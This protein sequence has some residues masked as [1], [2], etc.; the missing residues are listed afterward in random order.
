MCYESDGL[1]HVESMDESPL[2]SPTLEKPKIL[3]WQWGSN[4]S[5]FASEG[6]DVTLYQALV[7]FLVQS[8]TY[9]YIYIYVYTYVY[10]YICEQIGTHI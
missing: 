8:L 7:V 1:P 2:P 6:Q 9:V 5:I 10:V 4:G 3:L